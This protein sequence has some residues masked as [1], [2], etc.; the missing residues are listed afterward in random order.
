MEN[1]VKPTI[2]VI[3]KDHKLQSVKMSMPFW[4]H[5]NNGIDQIKLPLISLNTYGLSNNEEDLS[6]ALNES[7]RVFCKASEEFGLGLESE[8][9][10]AGW[11]RVNVSSNTSIFQLDFKMAVLDDVMDTGCETVLEFEVEK[12]GDLLPA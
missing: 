9:E 11:N 2:E 4:K 7:I 8:L 12:E 6:K 3:R 10:I 1:H 5:S